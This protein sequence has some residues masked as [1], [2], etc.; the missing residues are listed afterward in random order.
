VRERLHAGPLPV[1]ELRRTLRDLSAT[2]EVVSVLCETELAH[3]LLTPQPGARA[4]ALN[5]VIGQH[6]R[7][8]GTLKYLVAPKLGTGLPADTFETVVFEEFS[9]GLPDNLAP[10]IDRL[11]AML[12]A[13]GLVP[14][15]NGVPTDPDGTRAMLNQAMERFI[16]TR[17]PV[18]QQLGILP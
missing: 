11:M 1:A 13:R 7:Q 12:L 15:Q 17:L 6:N 8:G 2:R 5:R 14:Q 9:A 18:L 4:D 3:P 16:A 10:A